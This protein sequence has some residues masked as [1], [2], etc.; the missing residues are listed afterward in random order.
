MTETSTFAAAGA[1]FIRFARSYQ[2]TAYRQ[3]VRDNYVDPDEVPDIKRFLARE[4]L[5][6]SWMD[7]W[8][9]LILR[10]TLAG[11]RI[12][13]VRIVTEPWSDY[14]RFGLNLSRLNVAAGEDIR[15]LSR[16]HAD[17]LGLPEYDYW[18]LDS[19]K[20]CILR[21]DDQDVLLGADIVTDPAV[22]VEHARYRDIAQRYALPRAAYL[23]Q[24]G[25]EYLSK[26][27][28]DK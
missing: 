2:H 1:E 19:S 4:P 14:T 28:I 11:Q 8:L 22:V 6:E 5:D 18:L 16:D 20:M 3:E 9:G 13:R 27:N 7:D 10:R 24:F 25:N 17:G 15:Y 23:A 21:H 12:H 26:T